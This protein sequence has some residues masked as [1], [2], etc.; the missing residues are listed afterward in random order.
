MK[1]LIYIICFTSSLFS[2]FGGIKNIDPNA[3]YQL[4]SG[5]IISPEEAIRLTVKESYSAISSMNND[6]SNKVVLVYKSFDELRGHFPVETFDQLK[7]MAVAF[8][9]KIPIQSIQKNW[10]GRKIP[11]F[12]FITTNGVTLNSDS[13][14][15]KIIV[16]NFWFTTC[17]AC[18]KEIP[19][20]NKLVIQFSENDDVV[21]I[22]PALN[23]NYTIKSF[24]KENT[25]LYHC[26]EGGDF[27]N[28]LGL[29]GFP[30]HLIVGKNN[31]ILMLEQGYSENIVYK[32]KSTI[33]QAL[34]E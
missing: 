4:T 34:N 3:T 8:D 26:T 11:G 16:F 1:I 22:A 14:F 23:D 30:T 27:I 33:K 25:F 5:I 6:G 10:L 9:R 15:G 7:K 32:I 28:K 18:L 17:S 31:E 19:E 29:S 12:N 2:Q 20:L 24:L 21:F 13:L